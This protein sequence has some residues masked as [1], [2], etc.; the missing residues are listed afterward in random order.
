MW[1]TAKGAQQLERCNNKFFLFLYVHDAPNKDDTLGV[2]SGG[3]GMRCAAAA[4]GV[5]R[6]QDQN[7]NTHN[8]TPPTEN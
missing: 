7:K 6:R 8:T 4:A 1:R 3:G 2:C 5:V